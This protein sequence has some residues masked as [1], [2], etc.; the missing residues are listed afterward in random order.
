LGQ[1]KAGVE[2]KRTILLTVKADLAAAKEAN[3]ELETTRT[4][5]TTQLK[6]C[7]SS[8]TQVKLQLAERISQVKSL[9]YARDEAVEVALKATQ[10]KEENL[11]EVL[12]VAEDLSVEKRRSLISSSLRGE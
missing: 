9:M 4:D 10:D 11:K 6:Q 5:L 2:A 1:S 7:A 12:S 3:R 8:Q